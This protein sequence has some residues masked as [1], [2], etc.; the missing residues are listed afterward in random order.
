M[1]NEDKQFELL[2]NE[3]K[4]K[5][6]ITILT[7]ILVSLD[8]NSTPITFDNS[9]VENL[10]TTLVDKSDDSIPKSITLIGNA[11]IKKIE[12]LKIIQQPAIKLKEQWEFKVNYDDKGYITTIIAK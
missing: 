9:K 1:E 5:E 7:K 11:I 6:L 4:H 10:L 12:E 8:N 2:L 3:K